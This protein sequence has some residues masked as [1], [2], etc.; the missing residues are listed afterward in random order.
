ME[1]STQLLM[2]IA[3]VLGG[4]LVLLLSS[5]VCFW[6]FK[7]RKGAD[8]EDK[9]LT[10]KYAVNGM[11]EESGNSNQMFKRTPDDRSSIGSATSLNQRGSQSP[12]LGRKTIK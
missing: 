5:V 7:G 11:D 2:I 12:M 6:C 4:L 3:C 1:D 9:V 10:K 8:D